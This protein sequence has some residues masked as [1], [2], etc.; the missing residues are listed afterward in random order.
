MHIENCD[1]HG[2]KRKSE[3]PFKKKKNFYLY[4]FILGVICNENRKIA[5]QIII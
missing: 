4:I 5:E 1:D 2:N 3:F